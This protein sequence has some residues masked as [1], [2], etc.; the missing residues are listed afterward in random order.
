MTEQRF[1]CSIDGLAVGVTV[2]F[3]A[4]NLTAAAIVLGALGW[5]LPVLAAPVVLVMIAVPIWT[6]LVAP[7]AYLVGPAGLVVLRRVGRRE[8]PL[9]AIAGARRVARSDFGRLWRTF[10]SGGAHG[11][12]G[13][14]RSNTLGPLVL[15]ATRRDGWV[16]V[17][18]RD[19]QPHLVLSPD[20]PDGFLAALEA[21]HRSTPL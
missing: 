11:Y 17:E 15:E 8:V 2:F 18:R 6:M 10:G 13:R 12:F 16:L 4:V 21:A 20:D 19:G 14:F 5:H 1:A 7:R 3:W 9:S